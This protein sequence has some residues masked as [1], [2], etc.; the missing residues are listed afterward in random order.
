MKDETTYSKKFKGD[1]GNYGWAVSFD[2]ADGYVGINQHADDGM[3][4][5]LMTPSQMKALLRFLGVKVTT[6]QQPAGKNTQDGE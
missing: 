2:V 1:K 4:R 3:G 6:D 5:V